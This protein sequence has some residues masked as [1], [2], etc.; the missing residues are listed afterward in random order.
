MTDAP[1]TTDALART[2]L[3][4][5]HLERGARM[6]PFAG[7][8]MPLR[9]EAGPMA[10]HEHTRAA[11]SLFDV[12]HMGIVELIGDEA[13]AALESV[14]P[15]SISG[16][17]EQ[18]MRYTF[19][20]NDDGGIIDDL[21]VTNAGSVGGVPTLVLVVNA[22]NSETD[23]AHLRATIG[24]RVE[25]VER[26]DQSLVALQGPKAVAALAAHAPAVAELSF[27]DVASIEIDGVPIGVSRSGYTGEDGFELTLPR[28]ACR[29]VC[30]LLLDSADVELAGLA[31]RDSLRLEAGLCLHGN[32]IDATTSPIEAGLTWA[33]QKRRRTEG[34]FPGASVIQAQ[35]NDGPT[36]HR[37]GLRPLGRKPVR[38]SAELFAA[39][40][41]TIGTVTSG[42]FGPTV[43]GPVAMG[44]VATGQHETGTE[45]TADVR[46][47]QVPCV[48]AD[49]PF[50]PHRYQR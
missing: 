3:H 10:E 17:A 14:V 18:R 15:A 28:D 49:L 29:R 40:G 19:F 5:L 9:Y 34:G 25:I 44:Y 46:G 38:E 48:V 41:A 50:A 47:T 12:A 8:D 11:A 45:I 33:I 2:P 23:L 1:D 24:E 13:I 27:L 37:V 6:G 32:D 22:A 16:L 42:G 21:M 7:H 20:T 35:I 36:R 30:E 39:D 31:A 4:D 43:G 26:T